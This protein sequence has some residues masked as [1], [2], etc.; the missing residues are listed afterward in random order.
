MGLPLVKVGE[1]NKSIKS[2]DRTNTLA[3]E[4]GYKFNNALIWMFLT[5]K[6]TVQ[7]QHI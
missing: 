1:K 7:I 2:I 4:G 6:G 3:Y 5:F